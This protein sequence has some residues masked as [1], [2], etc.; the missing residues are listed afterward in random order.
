MKKH[1]FVAL[2]AATALAPVAVSARERSDRGAPAQT[3]QTR[4]DRERGATHRAPPSANRRPSADRVE[5]QRDP[6]AAYRQTDRGA[7]DNRYT[8][9]PD[10]RDTTPDTRSRSERADYRDRRDDRRDSQRGYRDDDNRNIRND[11]QGQRY[12]WNGDR[13]GDRYG[14]Q[15]DRGNRGDRG[16]WD[17]GWRHDN[18]Y[19]W[20]DY[21]ARN[22]YAYHLPRYYSPRGW[23][24][25]YRRFSIGVTLGSVLFGQN[26]WIGDPGY[27]RLPPAYGPYRWVRYYND[28]L[29]V[30]IR[31]GIVVDVVYDIFW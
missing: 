20:R 14:W 19:D 15:G 13:R 18:R 16:R 17:N 26:Y 6:R 29:L 4:G 11:R 21:R 8:Q 23:N 31:S 9:R 12:G 3:A 25:G 30:D 22:R 5:V 24:Y 28:A 2:I 27:Y 7:Q 10:R 1:I